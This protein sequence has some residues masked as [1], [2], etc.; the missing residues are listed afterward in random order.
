MR[1]KSSEGPSIVLMRTKKFAV[2]GDYLLPFSVE[3]VKVEVSEGRVVVELG[4]EEVEEVGG[5]EG[6]GEV[7][8]EVVEGSLE[9]EASLIEVIKQVDVV[10]SAVSSKQTHLMSVASA[11]VAWEKVK[12]TVNSF[13]GCIVIHDLLHDDKA[14]KYAFA[15]SMN[16]IILPSGTARF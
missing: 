10:V 9:E 13:G 2:N 12:N 5:S 16:I 6:L 15:F 3:D 14:M 1:L 8:G 4:F 7:G 11:M